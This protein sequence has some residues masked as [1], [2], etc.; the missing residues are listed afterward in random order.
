MRSTEKQTT[1]KHDLGLRRA[2]T[3]TANSIKK[4]FKS[5]R[6]SSKPC[7]DDET[8]QHET[9]SEK[10]IT[11][12]SGLVGHSLDSASE[13]LNDDA[14]FQQR[15][16]ESRPSSLHSTRSVRSILSSA[17]RITL[18]SSMLFRHRSHVTTI[19]NSSSLVLDECPNTS[20]YPNSAA[21]KPDVPATVADATFVS[22]LDQK[23]PPQTVTDSQPSFGLSPKH[24]ERRHV[25]SVFAQNTALSEV[26]GGA[27]TTRRY[28]HSGGLIHT[29]QR[30]PS[31]CSPQ[32][33][34]QP[35]SVVRHPP[36]PTH[37]LPSVP[38]TP[39]AS[40]SSGNPR[41]PAAYSSKSLGLNLLDFGYSEQIADSIMP[42]SPVE[43]SSSSSV[44]DL[45][46]SS[47]SSPHSSQLS[48]LY[49]RMSPT[50][51]PA[52]TTTEESHF[53]KHDQA[54]ISSNASCAYRRQY[55]ETSMEQG[56]GCVQEEAQSEEL[57]PLIETDV[58]ELVDI[59][60]MGEIDSTCDVAISCKSLPEI[61]NNEVA[62][63]MAS[64]S[65]SF[66]HR[67]CLDF[68]TLDF[69]EG[70]IRAP[71]LGDQ[72]ASIELATMSNDLIEDIVG[73]LGS[74]TNICQHAL[75]DIKYK[76]ED[77]TGV[78]NTASPAPSR[79]QSIA[80]LSYV[81]NDIDELLAELGIADSL[82]YN[83]VGDLLK[84]K[85]LEINSP[86][87][88]SNNEDSFSLGD[89][90]ELLEQLDE[91]A[92][93]NNVPMKDSPVTLST[94]SSDCK[95]L[96]VSVLDIVNTVQSL[97][98]VC[99][100]VGVATLHLPIVLCPLLPVQRVDNSQEATVDLLAP[101]DS[102]IPS[103]NIGSLVS[104]L[105]APECIV[106]ASMSLPVYRP[107]LNIPGLISDLG[108][109][110]LPNVV[111]QAKLDTDISPQQQ[112]NN[113]P[114]NPMQLVSELG[115]CPLMTLPVFPV[116]VQFKECTRKLVKPAQPELDVPDII[117]SLGGVYTP[118]FILCNVE[119]VRKASTQTLVDDID[120][121]VAASMEKHNSGFIKFRHMPLI[122]N[123]SHGSLTQSANLGLLGSDVDEIISSDARSRTSSI[124]SFSQQS[125]NFQ[126]I[127]KLMAALNIQPIVVSRPFLS[128]SRNVL[129]SQLY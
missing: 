59:D 41:S 28:S 97:G 71:A 27:E 46:L 87:T 77:N 65:S 129:F 43:S 19:V 25:L 57:A 96:N 126:C 38:H 13:E 118:D 119:R 53:E 45:S 33:D 110:V 17:K 123:K 42:S 108:S 72:Q 84:S 70:I 23:S 99:A 47:A 121:D 37:A 52:D 79:P 56:Y 30:H 98:D 36:M 113:T 50:Q 117:A 26:E 66:Q 89:I 39:P 35:L 31:M 93:Y 92:G 24:R 73:E 60:T 8:I 86:C 3:A 2:K 114:P 18:R 15:A 95:Q 61:E 120:D 49:L 64:D 76:K 74:V 16:I 67:L 6:D 127:S 1:R 111:C 40:Y 9:T 58:V 128:P 5:R 81:V 102:Q 55:M 91:A 94:V 83:T 63:N 68:G 10:D 29:Q 116:S 125:E 105:G 122:T 69:S 88:Y 85:E 112:E 62:V 78:E 124:A 20:L 21:A 11:R 14:N 82:V 54:G 51:M 4:L 109:I 115:C 32:Q 12:I 103:F 22:S 7:S 107:M 90:D 48:G 44:A 75:E 104:K 106:S 101:K 100:V 34:Q 80:K